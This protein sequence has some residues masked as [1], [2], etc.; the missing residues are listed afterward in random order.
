[1]SETITLTAAEIRDLALF[2]GFRVD[3]NGEETRTEDELE[4]EIVVERRPDGLRDD[5]GLIKHYAH[6]AYYAEYPEEGA[7]GLGLEVKGGNM[8]ECY[9][10][11]GVCGTLTCCEDGEFNDHGYPLNKCP[12][13]PCRKY[14]EIAVDSR[15]KELESENAAKDK[16]IAEL[17][18]E[19]AKARE[20]GELQETKLYNECQKSARLQGLVEQSEPLVTNECV[21]LRYRILSDPDKSD[22]YNAEIFAWDRW[23][24][25]AEVTK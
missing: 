14:T 10:S 18:A 9:F 11:T 2:C 15:I 24:K 13:F 8:S 4:T 6:V 5:D 20:L 19:L 25:D 23:L 7:M 22:D 17:K 3:G 21:S 1:M 16:E 12:N